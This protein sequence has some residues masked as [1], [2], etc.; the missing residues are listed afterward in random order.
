M[1]IIGT[2]QQYQDFV[3]MGFEPL[4]DWRKFEIEIRLRVQ[5]QRNIFGHRELTKGDIRASN[6]RFY[7]WCFEHKRQSCEETGQPIYEYSSVHVSHIITKG[8]HPEMAHDPRNTNIL[9]FTK[10]N[11]W[12]SG[13]YKGMKIYPLNMIIIELLRKEYSQL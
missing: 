1:N 7:R 12:E 4:I 11:R 13:N 8:S 6:D 5:I 10:H 3:A 9:I 2:Y